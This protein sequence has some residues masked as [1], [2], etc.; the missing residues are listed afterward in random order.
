MSTQATRR[1]FCAVMA[2]P[3]ASAT[4]LGVVTRWRVRRRPRDIGPS[5]LRCSRPDETGSRWAPS[6]TA[7]VSESQV[8][9]QWLIA[10]RSRGPG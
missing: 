2:D 1:L 8:N 6:R 9:C 3:A 5:A 10:Q 4:S 7:V